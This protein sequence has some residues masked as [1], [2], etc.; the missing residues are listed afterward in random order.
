VQAGLNRSQHCTIIW[1][2]K[3]GWHSL[4]LNDA[5]GRLLDMQWV[6]FHD[7]DDWESDIQGA[8][9]NATKQIS[10]KYKTQ[11]T[12]DSSKPIGKW[13]V[14]LLLLCCLTYL[15]IERKSFQ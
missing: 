11:I 15:W 6:Y 10:D 4:N 12:M 13:L 9:H 2:Q 14:A 5:D 8:N 7:K 1:P 3:A